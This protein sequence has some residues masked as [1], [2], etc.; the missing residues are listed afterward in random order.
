MC[1]S[2]NK[3]TLPPGVK[4]ELYGCSVF[5]IYIVFYIQL[6]DINFNTIVSFNINNSVDYVL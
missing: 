4:H 2:D 3:L 6:L 1:S 5:L